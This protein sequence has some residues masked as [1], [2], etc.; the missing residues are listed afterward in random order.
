MSAKIQKNIM[1]AKKDYIYNFAIYCCK[2]GKYVGVITKDSV[3]SHEIIEVTK[4]FPNNLLQ[5]KLFQQKL[6]QQKLIRQ[7]VLEQ[8]VLQQ[9]SIFKNFLLI[10][11]VL[12]IAVNIYLYL[13]KHQSKQ[14]IITASRHQ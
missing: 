11:I 7:K 5:Q 9:T 1:R 3:I 14:K 13:L 2:N 4:N 6:V 12:L 8:K 10:I